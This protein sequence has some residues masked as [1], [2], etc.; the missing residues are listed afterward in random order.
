MQY[1]LEYHIKLDQS[2]IL[3]NILNGAQ[4]GIISQFLSDIF[5]SLFLFNEKIIIEDIQVS[6]TPAYYAAV[7]S[8]MIAGFLSIFIDPIALIAFTTIT[9]GYVFELADYI[10]NDDEVTFTPK[11]DV[12]DIGITMLF[13][14]LFDPVARHQYLRFSQKR[15]LIEPTLERRNRNLGTTIFITVF[16]STYGFLKLTN[17]N[18]N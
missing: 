14:I 18:N 5:I 1:D 10:I 15:H 2:H 8:G 9:Y 13:V 3:P 12:F 17:P 11:E 4:F 6:Q 16:T 7:A